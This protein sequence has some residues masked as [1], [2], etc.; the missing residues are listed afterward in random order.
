[1][2]VKLFRIPLAAGQP[3]IFL[4]SAVFAPTVFMICLRMCA[5]SRV[6]IS[7]V[8]FRIMVRHFSRCVLILLFAPLP[9]LPLSKVNANGSVSVVQRR[10]SVLL[11]DPVRNRLN[12]L[13][14]VALRRME[15]E[16][17]LPGNRIEDDVRMH[18]VVVGMDRVHVEI[19]SAQKFFGEVLSD[20]RCGIRINSAVRRKRQDVVKSLRP[21]LL[22]PVLLVLLHQEI[23][24]VGVMTCISPDH[25]GLFRIADV[26][27]RLLQ[28]P[29]WVTLR[30]FFDA[31]QFCDCHPR[32]LPSQ[33]HRSSGRSRSDRPGR[34]PL[35]EMKSH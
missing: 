28:P 8:N 17:V 15:L 25:F 2:Q 35:C 30:F 20:L 31:D 6:R 29:T 1:M 26:A 24:S 5:S 33:P 18:V 13:L 10:Q 19:L 12:P 4:A 3:R 21:V 7:A 27:Q 16:P 23:S 32:T 11:A 9:C 22:L 14:P 34:R